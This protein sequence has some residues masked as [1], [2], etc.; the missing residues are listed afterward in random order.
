MDGKV[1]IQTELDTK[2]FQAQISQLEDKLDTLTKEY[3]VALKDADFPEEELQ[4]YQ[5]EIEKTSNK[6]Q[7]LRDRQ[8]Q[9]DK[10]DFKNVGKSMKD[11]V[12]SAARWGL[13]IFGVRSAFTAVRN[14]MNTIT[15]Q[16]KQ[17]AN[18][19]QFIKTALAYTLEP[20]I[21]AV[22]S[23]MKTLTQYVAFVVKA[24]T[25]RDIFASARKNLKEG[26]KSAKEI[27]KS[28]AGFDEAQTLQK[29]GNGSGGAGGISNIGQL[30]QGEIPSWLQWIADHKDEVIA[31]L[32]GIAGGL[33]AIQLGLSPLMGLGLGIALAGIV[34]SI[35]KIIE[36]INDPSFETF[37]EIC[38]GIA[39]AV[40][41]VALAFGA[42]PVVVGAVLGLVILE[43]T[44][45]YDTIIGWFDKIYNWIEGPFYKKIKEVFGP[46]AELIMAPFRIAI[47]WAKGYFESF[48]G[49]IK[50]IVNGIVKLFKGD[51][52]GGIKEAFSGLK[53][54][55]LAPFNAMISAL[56]NLI[57]GINKISIDIPD[58]VPTYGGKKWGFKIPTIP[59]LA[60][61][62]I[63]NMPGRGVPVGG[64]L[65]GERS[66]EGVIPLSDSQQMALIGEAIGRYITIN[67]TNI[68]KLDSRQL[69][70]EIRKVMAEND[71]ATNG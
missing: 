21:R 4:K 31:G 11:I 25:G 19:I 24:W 52:K 33:V 12:K 40:G 60:K 8:A 37:I 48:F 34:Y 58:W 36:F 26:A 53:D 47:G 39:V 29:Q 20:I 7:D 41:G 55:L 45:H 49:G 69:A 65:A 59:K 15:Q 54:I 22:V 44:K 27:N 30:S 3:E 70:K 46:F 13:A 63:V 5:V 43:L 6:I 42:W 17:L 2:S 68:T 56:N 50:K 16:D 62:G 64:A 14:A 35:E 51:F 28:M 71:F 9:L 38:E 18:D 23:L 66:M 1:V 57:K 32:I 61:G 10:I 67:L